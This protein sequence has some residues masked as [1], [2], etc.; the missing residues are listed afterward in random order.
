M[1]RAEDEIN[2]HRVNTHF[3][4][5][6][7]KMEN[8][9]LQPVWFEDL[10][11]AFWPQDAMGESSSA[12]Y[13]ARIRLMYDVILR[14][15]DVMSLERQVYIKYVRDM[16]WFYYGRFSSGNMIIGKDGWVL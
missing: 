5:F 13:G 12:V 8:L 16:N 6:L 9:N 3:H 1:F 7:D 10:N 14:Y 4:N 2:V 15:S 11:N